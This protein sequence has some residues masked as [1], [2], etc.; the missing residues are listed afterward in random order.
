VEVGGADRRVELRVVERGGE[1]RVAV[2][3]PDAGLA[4]DLRQHLPALAARLEQSG[5]R[6]EA[7]HAVTGPAERIRAAE[8]ASSEA[9]PQNGQGNSQS[10]ERHQDAPPRRPKPPADISAEPEKG[11]GFAWHLNSLA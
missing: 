7:W 8:P 11:P 3:T 9:Q 2:R 6:A 4:D 5:L 10:R 1:V